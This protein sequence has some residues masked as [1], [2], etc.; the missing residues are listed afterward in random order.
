MMCHTWKT[1]IALLLSSVLLGLETVVSFHHHN[2]MTVISQSRGLTSSISSPRPTSYNKWTSLHFS[3]YD[4]DDGMVEEGLTSDDDSEETSEKKEM[5]AQV[6]VVAV[7][8]FFTY[9]MI[10]VI[11]DTTTYMTNS[12]SQALDLGNVASFAGSAGS[13]VGTV[14]SASWEG[15][16][17]AIPFV[18]KGVMSAS[19][20][21]AP[22]VQEASQKVT[23]A[24][25]PFMQEAAH[26][27]SEATSPMVEQA[28]HAVNEAASPYVS[29]FDSTISGATDM[30]TST[31]DTKILAPIKDATDSVAMAVDSTIKDAAASVTSSIQGVAD[32][33][34]ASIKEAIPF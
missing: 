20:A 12:M 5:I 9:S 27:V 15:L 30:V 10:T 13:V 3:D 24:A 4:K 1:S 6:M 29:A 2:S 34:A 7:G 25:T 31:L 22:I 16:N 28:A 19:T 8:A 18:T 33:A 23:E 21:A 32:E 17:V 14:A 26:K 11:L